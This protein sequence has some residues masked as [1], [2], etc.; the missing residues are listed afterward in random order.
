M[1]TVFEQDS[2]MMKAG[3]GK[4]HLK[5]Q[6]GKVWVQRGYKNLLV[7]CDCGLSQEERELEKD[8]QRK[9]QQ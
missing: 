6:P 7:L 2:D 1:T 9:L 8:G 5:F 3:L 4:N